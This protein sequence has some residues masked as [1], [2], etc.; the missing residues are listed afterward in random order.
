MQILHTKCL[1]LNHISN[2]SFEVPEIKSYIIYT[3]SFLAIVRLIGL[4]L[5][6][7][8]RH[9]DDRR[10]DSLNVATCQWGKHFCRGF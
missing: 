7:E 2:P 9:C 10:G 5:H 8:W 1:K 3:P 6:G 4:E